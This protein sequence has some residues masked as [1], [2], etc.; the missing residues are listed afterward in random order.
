M[1]AKAAVERFWN[2]I[3]A[4]RDTTIE[5]VR[6]RFDRGYVLQLLNAGM[7]TAAEQSRLLHGLYKHNL[8]SGKELYELSSMANDAITIDRVTLL[9]DGEIFADLVPESPE[10]LESLDATID[11]GTPERCSVKLQKH[12]SATA[13]YELRLY[14]PANWTEAGALVITAKVRPTEVTAD[15]TEYDLPDALGDAGFWQ[16][17]YQA[18]FMPTF[19]TQYHKALQRAYA[20]GLYNSVKYIEPVDM[21]VGG[22]DARTYAATKT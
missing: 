22:L 11:S 16:A 13:I 17:C 4:A 15:A 21:G 6:A 12:D 7:R 10:A 9:K 18:T 19:E 14:P 2:T 5:K 3:A 1:T 8:T 20:S